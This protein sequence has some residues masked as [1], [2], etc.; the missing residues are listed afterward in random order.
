VKTTPQI[1]WTSLIT[2]S[3]ASCGNDNAA[4]QAPDE[5]RQIATQ[6]TPHALSSTPAVSDDQTTE[7]VH[8]AEGMTDPDADQPAIAEEESAEADEGSADGRTFSD[9][10]ADEVTFAPKPSTSLVGSAEEEE[11]RQRVN[12]HNERVRSREPAVAES[13]A[14]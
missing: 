8:L 12:R 4:P 3:L 1:L 2:M 14:N 9:D 10:T 11:F 13:P 6:S 7:E 5:A